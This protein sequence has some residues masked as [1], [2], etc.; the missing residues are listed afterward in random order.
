MIVFGDF[1]RAAARSSAGQGSFRSSRLRRRPFKL[2]LFTPHSIMIVTPALDRLTAQRPLRWAGVM[3]SPEFSGMVTPR[4]PPL[5]TCLDPSDSRRLIPTTA[6][7][8]S[9]R[10]KPGTPVLDT[11]PRRPLAENQQTHRA[12]RRAS[13]VGLAS[14]RQHGEPAAR[15]SRGRRYRCLPSTRPARCRVDTPST[16]GL[17]DCV[18]AFSGGQ[19]SRSQT[20]SSS[21]RQR[22]ERPSRTGNGSRLLAF[23][24]HTVRD[25]TDSNTATSLTVRSSLSITVT[26]CSLPVCCPPI[27]S[28]GHGTNFLAF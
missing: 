19:P 3:V 9:V 22:T 27:Y 18:P 28:W 21:W 14:A 20:R 5:E 2:W 12:G 11:S 13:A 4:C 15:S 24:F 6:P 23:S 17:S 26:N 16:L 25:D 10:E 8:A 1:E 7:S